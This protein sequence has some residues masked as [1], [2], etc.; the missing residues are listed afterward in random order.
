MIY[1]SLLLAGIVETVSFLDTTFV[2]TVKLE[3]IAKDGFTPPAVSN[4]TILNIHFSKTPSVP[5]T[6][7]EAGTTSLGVTFDVSE[8]SYLKIVSYEVL[9]QEY[10]PLDQKCMFFFIKFDCDKPFVTVYTDASKKL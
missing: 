5:V 3:I 1:S 7:I 9:V 4:K 2:T 8:F 6:N 10:I